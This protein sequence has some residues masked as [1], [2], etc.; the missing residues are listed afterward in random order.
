VLGGGVSV[1][2]HLAGVR[3]VVTLQAAAPAAAGAE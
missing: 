3:F 2:S 1:E